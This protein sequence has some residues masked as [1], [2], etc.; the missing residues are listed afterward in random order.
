MNTPNDTLAQAAA[1]PADDPNRKTRRY[2]HR[3]SVQ[4][5]KP[6]EFEGTT[7]D[8]GAGGVGVEVPLPMANGVAVVMDIFEGHAIAQGTVRWGRPHEGRYRVGIQFNDEDWSIIARVQALRGL[9]A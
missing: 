6:Y 5:R 9:Q 3:E 1:A 8:I 4:F 2:P 7:V